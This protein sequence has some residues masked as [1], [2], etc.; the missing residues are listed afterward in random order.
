MSE[1]VN[2][3]FIKTHDDAVLPTKA[4]DGDNCFDLYAVEDTVVR[5]SW[6][7]FGQTRVGNEVVPVGITVADITPG[8]GFVLRPKSGLGFKAGLQPHLGE[9]DNGYRGDCAVKM[10]NFSHKDYYFK[11]GDK[12]AQIKIEKIYDTKVSWVKKVTKAKRGDAG[13]GSSGK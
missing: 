1:K 9:I 2:I 12:V 4:H 13:F 5:G 8:Y 3:K 6:S 10:Y 11:K 7:W